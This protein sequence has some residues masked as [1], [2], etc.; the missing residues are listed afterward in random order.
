MV[1]CFNLSASEIPRKGYNDFNE[2]FFLCTV[3]SDEVLLK[4]VN[5]KEYGDEKVSKSF[6]KKH[7]IETSFYPFYMNMVDHIHSTQGLN[8]DDDSDIFFEK[9]MNMTKY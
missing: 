7:F 3:I 9:C 2:R 4:I 8:I 1:F 5:I 6:I